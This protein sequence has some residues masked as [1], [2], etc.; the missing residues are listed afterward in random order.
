MGLVFG[1]RVPP[2]GTLVVL[3]IAL[4]AALTQIASL[5]GLITVLGRFL[6]SIAGFEDGL[7]R[8]ASIKTDRDFSLAT[9]RLQALSATGQEAEET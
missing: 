7:G 3:L 2:V 4:L 6:D 1:Y 8:L 5:S 9:A